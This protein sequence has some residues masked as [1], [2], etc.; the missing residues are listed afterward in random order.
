MGSQGMPGPQ[1]YSGDEVREAMILTYKL[2]QLAP[3]FYGRSL[4]EIR[5]L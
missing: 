1:G 5:L 4:A 2:T 3:L